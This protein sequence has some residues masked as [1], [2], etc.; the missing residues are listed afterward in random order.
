[1]D[2]RIRT[3]TVLEF[4]ILLLEAGLRL[5]LCCLQSLFIKLHFFIFPDR[6]DFS[7]IREKTKPNLV[8]HTDS[9]LRRL[10]EG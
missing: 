9:L 6:Q 2:T 7:K 1:M 10:T 3:Y 8:P 5:L 4:S